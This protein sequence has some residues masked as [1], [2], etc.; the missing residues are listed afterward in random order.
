MTI[1]VSAVRDACVTQLSTITGLR[2]Y[3]LIPDTVNVPAAVVGNLEITWDEAM[4]R[5]LDQATFD[6]LVIASRMS[7]RSAQD[8]LDGYLAGTGS[9]SVK[10]V[11]E[12]G[13][14][15]G[16]LNG[17]V[18]TIRVTRATPIAITVASIE[19]LAYRYEV[20]IYG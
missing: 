11:L 20:E 17:T 13:I 6:V 10:T 14:P 2:C 16:T 3:D 8:K 4:Q 5:G 1:T 15:K 19:Y 9:S 18:S 7:D 12:A